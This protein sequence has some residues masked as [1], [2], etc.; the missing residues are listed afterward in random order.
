M[1][2]TK[3]ISAVAMVLAI[4]LLAIAV[5]KVNFSGAWTMDTNRSFGVPRDMQQTMTVTQADDKIEVETKLIQPGNERTVK[6]AFIFDGK[7]HD[8]DP[9]A[10][11]N[12]PANA[13]PPKGKRTAAWL[14]DGKGILLTES[15]TNET[16]QGS[17]T[18]QLQR[19]WT[20]TSDNE[21]TITTFVDGPRG[22]Y[23]AKRIFLRK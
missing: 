19:K 9:P 18:T 17:V 15:V 1:E 10:P 20:F 14:P 7:E 13:P 22:S 11:P 21:L 2:M 3:L 16:P 6:D 23:E 8:F 4:C 12:A 5:P